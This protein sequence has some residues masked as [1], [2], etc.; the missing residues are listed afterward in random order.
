M[1]VTPGPAAVVVLMPETATV[2]EDQTVQLTATATDARG[3]AIT[4]RSFTWTTSSSSIATVSPSGVVL[5]RNPGTVTI[6]AKLDNKSDTAVVTVT[7][8]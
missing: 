3:N 8:P 2:R 1:T 5:G 6:T 7:P 4:G